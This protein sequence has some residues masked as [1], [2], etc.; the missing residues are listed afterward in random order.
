MSIVVLI[1]MTNARLFIRCLIKC[2]IF[3]IMISLLTLT[4]NVNIYYLAWQN[5]ASYDI[6]LFS[7]LSS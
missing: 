6:V 2:Y 3:I 1:M 5:Y 4:F 7:F